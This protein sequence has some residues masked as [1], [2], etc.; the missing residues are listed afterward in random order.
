MI[1]RA[2]AERVGGHQKPV[3]VH[4]GDPHVINGPIRAFYSIVPLQGSGH[5]AFRASHEI[6]DL[7]SA[8]GGVV[9]LLAI[10]RRRNV[11]THGISLLRKLLRMR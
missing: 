2:L 3:P 6:K 10:S 7:I 4:A 5:R 8:I 11:H 1:P 9:N